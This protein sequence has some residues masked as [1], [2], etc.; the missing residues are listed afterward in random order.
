MKKKRKMQLHR[1][2]L[3]SL[4]GDDLPKVVGGSV[5]NTNCTICATNKTGCRTCTC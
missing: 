1:E 5:Q 2:T 4:Q 3:R